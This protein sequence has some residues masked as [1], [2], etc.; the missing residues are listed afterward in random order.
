MKNER[1]CKHVPIYVDKNVEFL[2]NISQLRHWRD[3]QLD[4]C[5]MRRTRTRTLYYDS[6]R[7]N[8][9]DSEDDSDIFINRYTYISKI[10][11]DFHKVIITINFKGKDRPE[12]LGYVQYY[13]DKGEHEIDFGKKKSNTI[14]FSMREEIRELSSNGHSGK[15]I[16]KKISKKSSFDDARIL[17]EIPPSLAKIYDISRSSK[18]SKADDIIE[19]IGRCNTEMDRE[20]AFLR[21][22]RSAPEFS[23]VL[24]NN[25]QLKDIL[26]FCADSNSSVLGVD[27]TFD[28][29]PFN[30]TVS[31]YR[32]P[33]LIVKK[34]KVHPTILGPILIHSAKTFSSYFTLPSTMVRLCP[35]LANIK[36]FGTDEEINVYRALQT[37]FK[38]ADHL[39]CSIH[40]KDNV[41]KKLSELNVEQPDRF[42]EEIF[43]HQVGD[44]KIKGL[45]DSEN[46]I[47]FEEKFLYL[48][49]QW[50]KRRNGKDFTKYIISYKKDEIKTKMCLSTR[51]R[52]G[53]G[54]D[55]YDQNC[56]ESTNSML[57]NSK[58]KG[59]LTIN[60]TIQL[61]KDE[62]ELQEE[63][64]KDALVGKGDWTLAPE[65]AHLAIS[66]V[67]YSRMKNVEKKRYVSKFIVAHTQFLESTSEI[68]NPIVYKRSLN[69]KGIV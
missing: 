68:D 5:G 55:S 40:V 66:D 62:V 30:T 15:S 65:Y 59:L 7:E 50:S 20:D 9:G 10:H 19:L 27:P 56:N 34:S 36:A 17:P 48:T 23:A 11:P 42:I 13:F 21:D 38:D 61:V 6:I 3:I 44:V 35:G 51:R 63:R 39:L 29:L 25:R 32:H 58:I 53:L 12:D 46:D 49:E 2:V 26:K 67:K 4:M 33:M 41:F 14:T 64:M 1:I 54:F 69:I 37:C 16:L 18:S 45:V 47:E 31:T 43:G 52:C 60:Q 24:G 57:K 22:V 8:F 28:L